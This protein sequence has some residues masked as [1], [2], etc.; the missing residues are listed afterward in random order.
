V[1]STFACRQF[2][3]GMRFLR[4]DLTISCDAPDRQVWVAIAAIG[5]VVYVIGIPL[6]YIR[7]LFRVRKFLNPKN[8]EK[9]NP[10]NFPEVLFLTSI[11]KPKYYWWEVFE[12]VRKL[13]QTSVIVFIVGEFSAFSP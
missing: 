3:G 12:L 1:L 11:Y 2:D 5:V 9:P 7:A 13:V 6:F 4:K 10:E 8:G